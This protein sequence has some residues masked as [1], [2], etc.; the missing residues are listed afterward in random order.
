MKGSRL[1]V[2]IMMTSETHDA[3]VQAD[4]GLILSVEKIPVATELSSLEL[5]N[6]GITRAE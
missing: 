2:G 6:G 3:D 5:N 4:H 1:Q